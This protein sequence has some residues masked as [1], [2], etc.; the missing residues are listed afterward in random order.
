MLPAAL[1]EVLGI[2]LSEVMEWYFDGPG[3]EDRVRCIEDAV[4]RRR[5]EEKG[6]EWLVGE[7]RRRSKIFERAHQN[8]DDDSF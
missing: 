3:E 6:E 8:R 4:D 5:S 7:A 2:S 1:S